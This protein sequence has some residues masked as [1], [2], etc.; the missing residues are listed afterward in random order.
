MR[1]RRAMAHTLAK[2]NPPGRKEFVAQAGKTFDSSAPSARSARELS[3]SREIVVTARVRPPRRLTQGSRPPIRAV[4]PSPDRS[5][6]SKTSAGLL[7]PA[8]GHI[9]SGGPT[10]SSVHVRPARATVSRVFLTD[11]PTLECGMSSLPAGDKVASARMSG[12]PRLPRNAKRSGRE[13]RGRSA[14]Q[15]HAAVGA[16]KVSDRRDTSPNSSAESPNGLS[17]GMGGAASRYLRS[18]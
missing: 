7:T 15:Q 14:S 18:S 9:G 2:P 5:T 17:C 8:G 12:R 13:E 6:P 3:K 4:A 16:R 10:D 1:T 11:R